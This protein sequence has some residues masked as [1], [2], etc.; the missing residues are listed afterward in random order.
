[1]KV[2]KRSSLSLLKWSI[3]AII[4]FSINFSIVLSSCQK[5]GVMPQF[6]ALTIFIRHVVD[7]EELKLFPIQY[8]NESGNSYMVTDLKYYL[9][10]IKLTQLN[11]DVYFDSQIHYV[12]IKK[13]NSL[14]IQLDSIKPGKY[15]K[16]EFDLGI[17]SIRNQTGYLSNNV[18]NLNMAWPVS[19]EGG[20]HFLKFEGKYITNSIPYGFAFHF[21]KSKAIIHYEINLNKSLFY[22]N[23]ELVLKHNL[24][25]WFK[26]PKNYNLE[27]DEPYIMNSDS[28]IN[29]IRQNGFDA[30]S[31]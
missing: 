22:W 17:D 8:V 16:L 31:I 6:S 23:E 13:M 14:S 20:Y 26:T 12:D 2:E 9:S 10:N 25:E 15:I 18:D 4:V 5:T 29:V 7:E 3:T 28:L 1:M 19:M 11:G 24:N 21:G 30:F 27:I